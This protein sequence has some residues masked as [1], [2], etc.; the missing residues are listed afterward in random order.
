SGSILAACASVTTVT[1]ANDDVA[2]KL[3]AVWPPTVNGSVRFAIDERHH[4]GRPM[5]HH[6]HSPQLATVAMTTWSPGATRVTSEPTASTTPAPSC[7]ISD[8]A[9]HGMVP[10]SK[11]TSLW[12]TPAAATRTST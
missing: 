7:P 6:L 9:G 4:A 3:P 10:S 1:S 5:L 11:L 12:Q 2:A 8:G